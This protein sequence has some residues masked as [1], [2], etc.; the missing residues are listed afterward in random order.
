[1]S[2]IPWYRNPN[3]ALLPTLRMDHWGW[4]LFWTFFR[5]WRV[6]SAGIHIEAEVT[7]FFFGIGIVFLP[8]KITVGFP[9][10]WMW[11]RTTTT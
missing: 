9:T 11:S 6:P 5:I 3:F 2:P 1:M 4:E 8:I 10:W 7:K